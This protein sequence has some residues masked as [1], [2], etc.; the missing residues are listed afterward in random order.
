MELKSDVLPD[1]ATEDPRVIA[2]L[3]DK[4]FQHL[5]VPLVQQ[6]NQETKIKILCAA[7]K[8]YYKYKLSDRQQSTNGSWTASW[9]MFGSTIT[10]FGF[11]NWHSKSSDYDFEG[12][13][14]LQKLTEDDPEFTQLML[15]S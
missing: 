11:E 7:Y 8:D 2:W 6:A 1:W 13:E 5:R 9:E 14:H 4:T 3:Q 15:R 10:P 12:A